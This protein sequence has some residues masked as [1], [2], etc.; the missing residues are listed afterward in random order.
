MELVCVLHHSVKNTVR[1]LDPEQIFVTTGNSFFNAGATK[2]AAVPC[3]RP[4]YITRSQQLE[5]LKT[6]TAGL[7]LMLLG[8][9]FFPLIKTCY[10]A[11]MCVCSF[12][13][14]IGHW[15]GPAKP[16]SAISPDWHKEI[17]HQGAGQLRFCVHCYCLKN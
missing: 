9:F 1:K 11:C 8:S 14:G 17:V 4:H 12:P 2:F 3:K 7:H 15:S 6:F 13:D 10:Y 5:R 16:G